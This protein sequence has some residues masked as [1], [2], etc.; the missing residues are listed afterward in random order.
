MPTIIQSVPIFVIVIINFFRLIT[1]E[2]ETKE[3]ALDLHVS[4][5]TI[6]TPL[7]LLR[8]D[9]NDI[10]IPI[11]IISNMMLTITAALYMKNIYNPQKAFSGKLA[12]TIGAIFFGISIMLTVILT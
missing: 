8:P 11:F 5:L 1:G 3:L 10:L 9:L 12:I 7:L 6:K 2:L 4:A